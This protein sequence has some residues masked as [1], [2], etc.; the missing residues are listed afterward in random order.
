MRRFRLQVRLQARSRVFSI[1]LGALACLSLTVGCAKKQ[2]SSVESL[3]GSQ[4]A[5]SV[6]AGVTALSY[7]LDENSG[8][9]DE[10]TSSCSARAW[11][12][13]CV[14]QVREKSYSECRLG[15]TATRLSGSVSLTYVDRIDPSCDLGQGT[16]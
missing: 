5:V 11:A 13:G 3:F 14:S 16:F 9:A 2:T 1:F 4:Q 6:V 7:L 15:D 8:Q 10:D 12:S